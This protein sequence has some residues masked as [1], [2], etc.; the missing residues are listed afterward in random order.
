[1]EHHSNPTSSKH[2]ICDKLAQHVVSDASS[3]ERDMLSTSVILK[4][5]SILLNLPHAKQGKSQDNR[6]GVRC[7]IIGPWA[8]R[9]THRAV[10]F[11]GQPVNSTL[12]LMPSVCVCRM[13]RVLQAALALTIG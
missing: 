6:P 8:C 7:H 5:S 11:E 2:A 12:H 4:H 13:W 10:S 1:M 3:L 9:L